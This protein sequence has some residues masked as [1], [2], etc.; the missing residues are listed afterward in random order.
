MP[1]CPRCERVLET[2]ELTGAGAC[3]SCGSVELEPSRRPVRRRPPGTRPRRRPPVALDTTVAD[4]LDE[5]SGT[6]DEG[7]DEDDD[8]AS[9]DDPGAASG[10]PK[11][12]WHFKLMLWGTA[13]YLSYRLYQGITWV[14]HHV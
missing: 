1:W 13:I 6:D 10:R 14:V 7:Q 4:E 12:P 2:D 8:D 9:E 11:P 3:P 5:A